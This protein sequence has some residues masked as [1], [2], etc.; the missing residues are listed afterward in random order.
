MTQVQSRHEIIDPCESTTGWAVLNTDTTGLATSTTHVT[1]AASLT[2][3]K[4]DGAANGTV[5]GIDKTISKLDLQVGPRDTI[6]CAFYLSSIANVASVF[7]R[8]GTN[9]SNYNSW[10]V[11]DTNITAGSMNIA[12][13][14]VGEGT[15]TGN[16][17][18]TSAITYVAVGV[19]F[20]AETDAL[21]GI[22][23]DHVAWHQSLRTDSA[24]SDVSLGSVTITGAALTA[25]QGT[26]T[27]TAIMDDWDESDRA[28]VNV[29][30][31][32]AG[33]AAGTGVDGVT[34]PRVTLATDVGLPAGTALLGKVSTDVTTPGTT[35]S[36][37]VITG[38]DGIAGGT[39]IDGATV[40]RVTLATDVGLPAGS[41]IIGKVATDVTTPGTTNSVAVITG[42]DG[43]AGGTGID[44]ATVPRVTLATD[45]ALPAGTNAI[46][47]LAANSGVDI[48]DVDVLSVIPGV[49]VTNLGK[50][51]GQAVTASDT[52]VGVAGSYAGGYEPIP[53]VQEDQASGDQ[54]RMLPVSA[55]VQKATPADTA[56]SA[57]DYIQLQASA[58]GLW[59]RGLP[60]VPVTITPTLDTSIYA[61]GDILFNPTEV[62]NAIVESAGYA[63]L[64]ALTVFDGDAQAQ[65]FDLIILQDSTT[66]GTINTAPTITDANLDPP[67]YMHTHVV[68]TGDYKT[69]SG[70]SICSYDF[71]EGLPLQSTGTSI[72]VAAILR[73]G[74]PTYTASGMKLTLWF[75]RA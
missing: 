31:G 49:G 61:S 7:I 19:N 69:V 47:K 68:D 6:R 50:T 72:Y 22:I 54:D 32:Q 4:V 34:V 18:D 11:A 27:S 58:G 73:S 56:G 48:G 51:K 66:F 75:A 55:V 64:K 35:N 30:V 24:E 2:F 10:T 37:A 38:Q 13:I 29:I 36:V 46:G 60:V 16:G 33:I 42:Q 44:G 45:V 3:N 25:V 9:S 5:A 71:G 41:A 15:S 39:G 14:N 62:A 67:N 53:I 20:D 70:A 74:T 8:I 40:P 28:K 12:D 17:W 52:L 63:K 43:I 59:V 1:G 65:S 23:F 26:A 57:G 21:S